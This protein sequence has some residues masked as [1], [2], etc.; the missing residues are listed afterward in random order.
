MQVAHL[1]AEGR[2]NTEIAEELGLSLKTIDH[3]VSAVL[4]KLEVRSRT[5]AA[6]ALARLERTPS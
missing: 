3:H 6:V 1:L 5:E 2:R 4:A